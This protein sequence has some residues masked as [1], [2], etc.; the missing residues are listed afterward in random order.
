[1]VCN[2]TGVRCN[3][4]RHCVTELILNDSQLV[5]LLS[6]IIANL[7]Q[8][9]VLELVNNNFSGIIPPEFSSLQ[10][11]LCW[12]SFVGNNLEG[13][14]PDSFSILTSLYFVIPHANKLMSNITASFSNCTLLENVDLFMNFLAG[15]ISF[16]ITNASLM[17]N[18]DVE[19]DH[20]SG[21]LPSEIVAK[22]TK[23]LYLCLSHNDEVS[24]DNNSNIVPS[25]TAL[26]NCTS[27]E[28]LGLVSMV[29]EGRQPS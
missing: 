3:K 18:L 20:V 8:L 24:H 17:Y 21:E 13:Q 26:T 2:F 15:E 10:Q 28:Y 25:F 27:L 19:Y 12:L 9:R 29:L 4:H 5:G 16:S 14:I 6:P 22:L 7:T 11:R 1:M 23:L